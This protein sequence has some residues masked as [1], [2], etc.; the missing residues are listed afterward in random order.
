MGCPIIAARLSARD[1]MLTQSDLNL[2]RASAQT[3]VKEDVLHRLPLSTLACALWLILSFIYY[4]VRSDQILVSWNSPDD[5]L[6]LLQI[7]QW[8][9]GASWFAHSAHGI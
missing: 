6:R 8:L 1:L 7:R 9:A 2:S 3:S 5:A 4:Q